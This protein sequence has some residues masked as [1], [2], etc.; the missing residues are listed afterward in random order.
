M[1]FFIRKQSEN[2]INQEITD[3]EFQTNKILRVKNQKENKLNNLLSKKET[4]NKE[5]K[6]LENE[7]F[8]LIEKIKNSERK[9]ELQRITIEQMKAKLKIENRKNTFC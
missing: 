6:E 2:E 9:N 5:L 7:N 1:G 8:L 4:E 3:F